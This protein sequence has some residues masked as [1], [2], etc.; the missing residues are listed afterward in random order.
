MRRGSTL[1]VLFLKRVWS[2]TQPF[3]KTYRSECGPGLL[4]V[5]W[6]RPIN[7]SV[8]PEKNIIIWHFYLVKT[9]SSFWWM[10][11][12]NHS[13]SYSDE[14]FPMGVISQANPWM[15]FHHKESHYHHTCFQSGMVSRWKVLTLK[16]TRSYVKAYS[17]RPPCTEYRAKSSSLCSPVP[18]PKPID[19]LLHF[20]IPCWIHYYYRR[21]SS[22][23]QVSMV[24][25]IKVSPKID[26]LRGLKEGGRPI[27]AGQDLLALGRG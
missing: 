23:K 16:Y 24:V 15:G 11:P 5:K 25:H 13:S 14:T 26:K 19:L 27:G 20:L 22:Y 8:V 12:M 1:L 2:L 7:H 9:Y 10:Y 21:S 18:V 3:S 6:S 4:L 17:S